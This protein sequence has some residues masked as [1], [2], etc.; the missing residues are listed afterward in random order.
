MRHDDHRAA[1]E[2]LVVG[3]VVAAGVIAAPLLQEALQSERA[4]N[5]RG[6]ATACPPP[7]E[8]EQ[9]HIVVTVRAGQL[10]SECMYVGTRGSYTKRAGL[11][12]ST[13]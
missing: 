13:R 4:G 11:R 3:L 6:A 2:L 9:L 1:V 12:A 10:H 7:S 8:L 5:L